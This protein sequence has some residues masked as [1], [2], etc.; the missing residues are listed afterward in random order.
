MRIIAGSF[1]GRQL[2]TT[3]D[4]SIRPTTDRA[5][6]AIFDILEN[7]IEFTGIEVL[8]LFSGSGSLG[9]EALSRGA[10][11][12]TFVEKTRP[13]IAILEKNIRALDCRK[14]T[15]IHQADVFWFLKNAH[16][17]FDLIFVDPP[18]RMER[19]GEL[20]VA[21]V[22]SK[23]LHPGSLVVLEH[24]RESTVPAPESSFE[25]IR[26]QSGQTMILILTARF[27]GGSG[28]K[29]TET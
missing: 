7:R 5:K 18:Y 17:S 26:R 22:S 14:Q 27:P 25:V 9:L 6:Q 23:V 12:V 28:K 1:R 11:A 13:S 21:I 10:S 29:G 24:S 20:P 4:R 16:R 3:R 2:S 8:D 15:T 19:I